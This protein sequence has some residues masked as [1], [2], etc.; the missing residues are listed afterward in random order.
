MRGTERPSDQMFY[1]ENRLVNVNFLDKANREAMFTDPWYTLKNLAAVREAKIFYDP[2]GWYT[3]LQQRARDFTWQQV[4]KD[5]DQSVSYL[6]AEG[7][8]MVQKILSGLSR[9][10][11]EKTLYATVDL[12]N[13]LTNV[14]A[15]AN[16]VLS[17]SENKFW[18]AVR[19]SEP[20]EAWKNFYWTALGFNGE[21]VV[22]RARAALQLYQRSANLYAAKLL[23]QH[24][25]I[26]EHVC[27]LI[28]ARESYYQAT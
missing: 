25:E 26:L 10:D 7:A 2:D 23:P 3:D 14:S 13:S 1:R 8:E 22:T 5:A 20:D 17:N 4:A 19:D 28:E 27:S 9:G 18:R 6:L 16:G 15:L 11:P 21:S 24:V 12:L